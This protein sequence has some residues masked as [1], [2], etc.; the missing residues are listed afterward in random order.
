MMDDF[1]QK[2]IEKER[3][4]AEEQEIKDAKRLAEKNEQ[5]KQQ[6]LAQE[7]A[8]QNATVTVQPQV[9][10]EKVFVEEMSE[11]AILKQLGQDIGSLDWL[12]DKDAADQILKMIEALG[13]STADED[14][15]D[16]DI[17][18]KVPMTENVINSA[19]HT[20]L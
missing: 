2:F 17:F 20:E 5:K 1:E 10:K 3:K 11:D 16:I 14:L 18:T 7:N 15:A 4:M 13:I 12:K 6:L 9:T 19:L 8:V